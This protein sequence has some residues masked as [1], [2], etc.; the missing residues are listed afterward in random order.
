MNTNNQSEIEGVF[1]RIVKNQ[2]PWHDPANRDWYL[3]DG[4]LR[5]LMVAD[6]EG[7]CVFG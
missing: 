1:K 5:E 7:P 2:N 3:K 6:D 4:A